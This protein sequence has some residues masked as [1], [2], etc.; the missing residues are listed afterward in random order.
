MQNCAVWDGLPS[1]PKVTADLRSKGLIE[2]RGADN[3]LCYRITDNGLA[4]K[5]LPIVTQ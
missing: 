5:K 3:G 2:R 1:S 4:A